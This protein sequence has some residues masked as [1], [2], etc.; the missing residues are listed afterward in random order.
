MVQLWSNTAELRVRKAESR[1]AAESPRIFFGR[2]QSMQAVFTGWKQKRPR[3][4]FASDPNVCSGS[5]L[6]FR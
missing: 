1:D 4:N 6:Y 3:A 2:L 5:K